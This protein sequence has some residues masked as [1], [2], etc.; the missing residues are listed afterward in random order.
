MRKARLPVRFRIGSDAAEQPA[1]TF[2]I[3]PEWIVL[4]TA[5]RLDVGTRLAITIRIPIDCVGSPFA[6]RVGIPARHSVH[7]IR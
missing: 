2:G 4:S 5:V 7:S 6:V 3:S 1:E